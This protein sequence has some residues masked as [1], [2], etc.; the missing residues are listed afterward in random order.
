MCIEGLGNLSVDFTQYD[1]T[2][3]LFPIEYHQKIKS[4]Y[5]DKYYDF[6]CQALARIF[7]HSDI[8]PYERL[9]QNSNYLQDMMLSAINDEPSHLSDAVEIATKEVFVQCTSLH[10]DVL[11]QDWLTSEEMVFRKLGAFALGIARNLRAV[12]DL[13]KIL[14]NKGE[15]IE[16]LDE[17]STALGSIGGIDAVKALFYRRRIGAIG[18]ALGELDDFKLYDDSLQRYLQLLKDSNDDE[19]RETELLVYRAIG[20]K[21][22]KRYMSMLRQLLYDS[23]PGFRGVAALALA[24]INGSEELATLTKAYEESKSPMESIMT[25]LGLL[26]IKSPESDDILGRLRKDLTLD[27]Q[28]REP[29]LSDWRF[30]A[31]ILSILRNARKPLAT[32]IANSWELVYRPGGN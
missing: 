7:V 31:D 8:V 14:D 22:D 3:M 11:V 2:S 32:L 27:S 25:G 20:L 4:A 21:K 29:Y 1:L 5:Y 9:W 19:Y 24:R 6:V 15:H 13:I 10:V 28:T 18:Y 12:P 17:V 23:R 26:L 16:V 30:R